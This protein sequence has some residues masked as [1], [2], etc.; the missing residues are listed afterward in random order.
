MGVSFN[1]MKKQLGGSIEC[2]TKEHLVTK[3]NDSI[4][5]GGIVS[6]RL[7]NNTR[8]LVYWVANNEIIVGI[9]EKIVV[10]LEPGNKK[11]CGTIT[12]IENGYIVMTTL[13]GIQECVR[14]EQIDGLAKINVV[15][16]G[17]SVE[18]IL[19]NTVRKLLLFTSD[20]IELLKSKNI[21]KGESLYQY[22]LD[23]GVERDTINKMFYD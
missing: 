10:L 20:E 23:K 18:P 11:L 14:Y 3:Q 1:E 5:C 7:E 22:L 13:E 9:G 16:Q 17:D 19:D 15:T 6:L 4:L 12:E 21:I 2:K 8:K